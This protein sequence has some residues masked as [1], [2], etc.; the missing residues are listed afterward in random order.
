[1]QFLQDLF[2]SE[3]SSTTTIPGQGGFELELQNIFRQA[4]LPEVFEQS[5]YTLEEEPIISEEEYKYYKDYRRANA[6]RGKYSR[7]T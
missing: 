2:S 3:Q 5:G 1:M 7:Q 6:R 4:V